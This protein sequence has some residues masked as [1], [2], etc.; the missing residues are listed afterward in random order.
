MNNTLNILLAAV[1]AMALSACDNTTDE[2]GHGHDDAMDTAEHPHGENEH[3][4]DGEATHSHDEPE[5]EVFYADEADA[6]AANK[7]SA[8]DHH[9]G[10]D[11]VHHEHEE[12]ADDEH[13][14]DNIDHDHQHENGADDHHH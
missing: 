6:P 4:H 13:H 5:T 11:E 9:D 2:H 1:F 3:S 12:H 10:A 14:N 8:A 7:D